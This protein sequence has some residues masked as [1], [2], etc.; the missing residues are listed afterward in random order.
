MAGPAVKRTR[1][2]C[3]LMAVV[4]VLAR[5]L[6]YLVKTKLKRCEPYNPS[7]LGALEEMLLMLLMSMLNNL[8]MACP[9]MW[10]V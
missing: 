2:S 4:L 10:V 1:T 9:A 3:A 5:V 8:V 6:G 7:Y